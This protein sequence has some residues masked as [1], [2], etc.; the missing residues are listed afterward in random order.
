MSPAGLLQ[1]VVVMPSLWL[2]CCLSPLWLCSSVFYGDFSYR[3]CLPWFL[4]LPL[5]SVPMRRDDVKLVS[6]F[7]CSGPA[8]GSSVVPALW[9]LSDCAQASHCC[10]C[11]LCSE[12]IISVK[13]W[14]IFLIRLL[15]IF[16]QHSYLFKWYFYLDKSEI[17]MLN[18]KFFWYSR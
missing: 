12:T 11:L 18:L 10:P 6:W 17:C 16:W 4:W 1:R 13:T 14:I 5:I 3:L 7:P 9:L 8:V 2:Y 15:D